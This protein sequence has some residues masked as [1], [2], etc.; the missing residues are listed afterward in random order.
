MAM[1]LV[2]H[3]FQQPQSQEGSTIARCNEPILLED[4]RRIAILFEA[5]CREFWAPL[6]DILP[7]GLSHA[8]GVEGSRSTNG[9][10]FSSMFAGGSFTSVGISLA[11]HY[12]LPVATV[13][14]RRFSAKRFCVHHQ[15][16]CQKVRVRLAIRN[17]A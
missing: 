5:S 8:R 13:C 7:P 14:N 15:R 1:L 6:I 3:C 4:Y 9:C 16:V 2:P 10:T 17:G 11:L 12:R